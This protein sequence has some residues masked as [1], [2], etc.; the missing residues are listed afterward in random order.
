[1]VGFY[2]AHSFLPACRHRVSGQGR[3]RAVV[4][5]ALPLGVAIV[6]TTGGI[7]AAKVR[8]LYTR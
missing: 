3:S 2:R 8:S 5:V 7:P 4:W 6:Y 1:M